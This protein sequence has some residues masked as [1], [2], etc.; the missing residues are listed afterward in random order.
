[1]NNSKQSDLCVLVYTVTSS[2]GINDAL[3]FPLK[4]QFSHASH[5]LVSYDLVTDSP[6]P[7]LVGAGCVVAISGWALVG[8]GTEVP[9]EGA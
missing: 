7:A 8:A 4:T 2:L 3:L 1:M 9:G 6:G 5:E